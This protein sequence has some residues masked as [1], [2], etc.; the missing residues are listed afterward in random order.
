M[1]MEE[2]SGR[3]ELR[4]MQ[5]EQ[6][7]ERRR[8]RDRQRRQS[9]TVEQREKHLARRRRN[10]QLRRLRAENVR[11]GSQ[12]GERSVVSRNETITVNEHQAVISVS[13]PSDQCNTVPHVQINQGQEKLIVECTKSEGLEALAHKSAHFQRT[14]RL[15]HVRHLARTLNHSVGE[16]TGNCQVVAA[17]V[18]KGDVTSNRSPVGDSDSGRSLQSLRLNRVK[19]LARTVNNSA[20][21]VMKE[22]TGQSDQSGAE[23]QLKLPWGGDTAGN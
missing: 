21:S 19:R 11:L 20:N 18:N 23:V 4:R 9:M 14:L 2:E 15:S 16:L 13:G 3:S 8:I 7:R 5:R 17:V 6:E 12:T 22:A 1:R 10:Y